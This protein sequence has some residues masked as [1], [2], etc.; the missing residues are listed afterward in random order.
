MKGAAGALK[1]KIA[2]GVAAGAVLV[3]GAGIAL[4][5]SPAVTFAD[6]AFE[7]NIRVLLDIPEGTIREDDLEEIYAFTISDDE[8]GIFCCVGEETDLGSVNSLE[9][10][11][12]FSNLSW[13]SIRLSDRDDAY[14]NDLLGTIGE[15]PFLTDLIIIGERWQGREVKEVSFVDGVPNLRSV[16]MEIG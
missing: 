5:Q 1:M 11:A 7:Q 3:G 16:E 14:L 2:A 9:D 13:V 15:N 6:P 8:M 4:S 10:L 12:L